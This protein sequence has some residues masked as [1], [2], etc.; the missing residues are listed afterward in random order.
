MK[1]YLI[2]SRKN[3]KFTEKRAKGFEDNK[4]NK[5]IV[6]FYN[7]YKRQAQA[8]GYCGITQEELYEL[9][10][11]DENKTLPLNVAKKRSSG[12]LE[13][14]RL[15]CITN[16]YVEDNIILACPLC[17]NAKSNLINEKN[18]ITLFVPPMR[19]YYK[20]LLGRDLKN[21]CLC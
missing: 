20:K 16:I 6:R 3:T 2:I 10:T 9:F 17:N 8:C 19:E 13:I 4:G 15:D 18:W 21:P 12:T 7:W 14:E 5:D 11:K 1:Y